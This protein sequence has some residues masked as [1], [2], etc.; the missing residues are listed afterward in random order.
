MDLIDKKGAGILPILDDQVRT[1]GGTDKS[2]ANDLYRKCTDHPRFSAS[3]LQV[4]SRKFEL[5]HYAGGV[6]YDTEGFVSKNKDEFPREASDLLESSTNL[7]VKK[8]AKS[9]SPPVT[10]KSSG[11]GR[12]PQRQTVGGQFISQLQDLRETIS[13]TSPHYIRCKL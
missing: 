11:R 5:N 6:E 9:L 1:V 13:S 10:E 7:F 2:F 8:L 4:G 3:K 12:K